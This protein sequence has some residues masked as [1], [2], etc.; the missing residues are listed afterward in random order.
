MCGCDGVQISDAADALRLLVGGDQITTYNEAG[1]QYEVHIRA[2]EGNRQ[3]AAAIGQLTVPSSTVGSVP[4]NNI[5]EADA[6][7]ARRRRS[8]ASTAS[9]R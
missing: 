2:V 1:E 6:G 9:A 3:T 4:L 8:T 5:A 7:H